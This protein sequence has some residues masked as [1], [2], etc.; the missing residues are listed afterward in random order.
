MSKRSLNSDLLLC[1]VSPVNFVGLQNL[2]EKSLASL[3]ILTF[4]STVVTYAF[5]PL[6]VCTILYF[7]M[8]L[9]FD[10][11]VFFRSVRNISVSMTKI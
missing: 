8:A 10:A 4:V 11:L 5:E 3:L 2:L 6:E 9:R 1:N 7:W